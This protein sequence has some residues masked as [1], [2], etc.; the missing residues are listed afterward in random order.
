MARLVDGIRQVDSLAGTETGKER[1]KQILEVMQG[2]RTVRTACRTLH[3]SRARFFELKRQ[4]LQNAL[5][6]LA[7]KAAGRPSKPLP[8]DVVHVLETL[9]TENKELQMDLWAAEL[10]EELALVFPHL[11]KDRR[12]GKKI[13]GS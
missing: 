1:L 9:R 3:I 8:D 13:S 7:P 5:D 4:A 12:A 10:R 2:R 6:G 11:L